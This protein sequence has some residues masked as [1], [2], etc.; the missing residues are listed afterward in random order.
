MTNHL[1]LGLV[2]ACRSEGGM[3]SMWLWIATPLATSATGPASRRRTHH[4]SA[5]DGLALP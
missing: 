4:K 1:L 3:V 5:A 2:D